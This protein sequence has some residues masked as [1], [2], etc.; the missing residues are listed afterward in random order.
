MKTKI[1][2]LSLI[3]VFIFSCKSDDENAGT[4]EIPENQK[5]LNEITGQDLSI[6][7]TYTPDKKVESVNL[8]GIMLYLFAYSGDQIETMQYISNDGPDLLYRFTYENNRISSF[9]INDYNIQMEWNQADRSY[10]FKNDNQDE[11]TIILNEN[12]D[13][14]KVYHYVHEDDETNMI[15]YFYEDSRKGAM[16]NSNHV[17]TYMTIASY[18]S[19]NSIYAGVL[20]KKP[21]KTIA[22]HGL[23]FSFENTY[24]S[25]EFVSESIVSTG[26]SSGS[27]ILYNYKQ[28]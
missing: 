26:N 10:F 14:N 22:F 18:F 1:L 17:S 11:I 8:G 5:Y 19:I 12:E 25:Q 16:T 3:S 27:P 28:L 13:L 15:S 6:K 2:I 7:L 20:S 23:I 21:V 9:T 24:D 4:P